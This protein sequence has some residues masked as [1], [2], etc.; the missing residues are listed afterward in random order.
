MIDY[1]Y[2]YR[3]DLY[4]KVTLFGEGA[5]LPP[6]KAEKAAEELEIAAADGEL[7]E[8][9]GRHSGNIRRASATIEEL[10]LCNDWSWFAT[11]TLSPDN[12]PDRKDLDAFRSD[13]T[14]FIRDAR[15]KWSVDI[16]YLLVPELHRNKEGWHMHG[17]FS[18]LPAGCLRAFTTEEKLP[19]YLRWKLRKGEPI[20]DW[21][22]Y[23]QRFGWCDLEPVRDR[24]AASR[25][26]A[27]YIKKGMDSTALDIAKGKQLYYCSQGLSRRVPLWTPYDS[28]HRSDMRAANPDS[29][30]ADLWHLDGFEQSRL[31]DIV[32]WRKDDAVDENGC[33]LL[34][35]DKY[36]EP[37]YRPA[38]LN[39]IEDPVA[40]Y[41]FD[42][43]SV[44]WYRPA[45]PTTDN[46]V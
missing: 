9:L 1:W 12:Y 21:P 11:L 35:T 13:L 14:Q 26:V 39:L 16:A 44:R 25:Y 20:Y 37:L 15:K 5:K 45:T 10:A 27:K 29:L 24:D 40:S 22:G 31:T 34:K 41:D 32:L 43:G 23:R 28:W 38:A 17:F 2:K 19:H 8:P 33:L 4:K 36:G 18:G 3:D 7:P 6:K 42:Y 46:D 30:G